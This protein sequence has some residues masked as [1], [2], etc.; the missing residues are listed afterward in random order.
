MF[1]KISFFFNSLFRIKKK[2]LSTTDNLNRPFEIW[3]TQT[4]KQTYYIKYNNRF[5]PPL[6]YCQYV[7]NFLF[8][9]DNG[10]FNI[11]DIINQLYNDP[12]DKKFRP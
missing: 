8:E 4:R 2:L 10:C 5:S 11:I 6:M 12:V 1:K 9:L 3:Y 7:D